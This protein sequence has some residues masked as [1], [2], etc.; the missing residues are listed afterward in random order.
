MAGKDRSFAAR[1]PGSGLRDNLFKQ[2]KERERGKFLPSRSQKSLRMCILKAQTVSQLEKKLVLCTLKIHS[3]SYD[4][5][6]KTCQIHAFWVLP[7]GRMGDLLFGSLSPLLIPQTQVLTQADSSC[8]SGGRAVGFVWKLCRATSRWPVGRCEE[9]S[10]GRRPSLAQ[11]AQGPSQQHRGDSTWTTSSVHLHR[12]R[13]S[14][15]SSAGR[16]QDDSSSFVRLEY[17]GDYLQHPGEPLVSALL[18]KMA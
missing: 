2:R 10:T 12:Q 3:Q 6:M 7:V 14:Q 4:F 11:R 13:H 9:L 8:P 1:C 18:N 17:G 16:K 5:F 15:G